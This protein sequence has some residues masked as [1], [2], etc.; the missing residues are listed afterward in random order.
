M[1]ILRAFARFAAKYTRKFRSSPAIAGMYGYNTITYTTTHTRA[2]RT[3]SS[4]IRGSRR[5]NQGRH[6]KQNRMS[7][8]LLLLLLLMLSLLLN[9]HPSPLAIA[10]HGGGDLF[11]PVVSM[12]K[13]KETVATRVS[14]HLQSQR[15]NQPQMFRRLLKV[16]QRLNQP[17]MFRRCL[18]VRQQ[19]IV[20]G[21]LQ[22]TSRLILIRGLPATLHPHPPAQKTQRLNQPQMLQVCMETETIP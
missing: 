15:L 13:Y 11:P 10:G 2:P 7:Q 16:R 8:G 5:L 12:Q 14:N 6:R 21:P 17:H 22:T 20:R 1:L 19:R 3:I 9:L 18:K 4:S